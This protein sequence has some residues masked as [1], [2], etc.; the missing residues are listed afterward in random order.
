MI[1]VRL[2]DRAFSLFN[3]YMSIPPEELEA[4]EAPGDGH[5]HGGKSAVC[6]KIYGAAARRLALRPIKT[7]LSP[8]TVFSRILGFLTTIYPAYYGCTLESRLALLGWSDGKGP[9]VSSLHPGV[10]T[11]VVPPRLHGILLEWLAMNQDPIGFE[12]NAKRADAWIQFLHSMFEFYLGSDEYQIEWRNPNLAERAGGWEELWK[13]R[14][15]WALV[16]YEKMVNGDS[17]TLKAK[18]EQVSKIGDVSEKAF[19]NTNPWTGKG[20]C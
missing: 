14:F 6:A 8:E 4:G 5:V 18:L 9:D 15:F 7:P 17:P 12:E 1:T 20:V 10:F 16:R 3:G 13:T 11:L 2:S 19:L